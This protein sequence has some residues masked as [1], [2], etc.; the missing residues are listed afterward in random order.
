MPERGSER[1]L[2][3]QGMP[4]CVAESRF[5]AIYPGVLLVLD[6]QDIFALVGQM[7]WRVLPAAKEVGF[8]NHV[9]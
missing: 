5:A 3:G 8:W 2:S 4:V 9:T 6:Q 1:T 7:W